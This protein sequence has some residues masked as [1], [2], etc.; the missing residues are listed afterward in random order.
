MKDVVGPCAE[1]QHE[2][3]ADDEDESRHTEVTHGPDLPI[4]RASVSTNSS[5]ATAARRLRDLGFMLVATSGT[6]AA[7]AAAASPSMS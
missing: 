6:A 4:R 7:I 2:R 5:D 3:Q 1:R